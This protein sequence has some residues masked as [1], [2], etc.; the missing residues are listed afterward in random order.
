M[1]SSL[2]ESLDRGR[3]MRLELS[4]RAGNGRGHVGKRRRGNLQIIVEQIVMNGAAVVCFP[5]KFL[6]YFFFK[7]GE[8]TTNLACLLFLS[9][10]G[11]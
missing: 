10:L 2:W 4:G 9:Y 1:E 6:I 7:E 8:N 11:K 3:E 5:R